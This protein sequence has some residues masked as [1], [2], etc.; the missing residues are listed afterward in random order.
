MKRRD[1]FRT[2]VPA[3]LLPS[4]LNGFSFR[5]FAGSP[6]MQALTSATLN[7]H[8]LI[9]IQLN[10]GNDGLNTV[11]PLDQYT[12][13]SA[14]RQNI[15]IPD[16]QVLQLNGY[17]DTGLHPSMTGMRQLFNDG[18]LN[19]VQGVGYPSP[20]FSH[21]RATDIWLTGSDSSQVLSSGWAGRYLN[22]EYPNFPT[23]YPNATMPDPLALQIGSTV[24]LALQGPSSSMAMAIS[25][26]TS[27]YNLINGVQDP[28]P[29][30]FAGKELTYIRTVAQQST[31]YSSVI[32]AAANNIT[33]QSSLYPAAGI[34]SLADQLKIVARLIAGGLKTKIY[35]VNLGG[36]DTH[37]SQVGTTT[38]SGTH[39]DLLAK[40][41]EAITAFMDD[42][43][44]LNIEHRVMGM[45]FSEFGRRIV[46]NSSDG[47]DHG[48]AAPLFV[49]GKDV[50][51]GILGTNPVIGNNV[52]VND[53]IP[54]QYD[55]RSVYASLLQDWFCVPSTDL[56]TVL[57]QNFQTLPLVQS[58]AC[59]SVG[60][61]EL[62]KSA[63]INLIENYPNP[64]SQSTN[65]DF[66]TSGGHTLVQ[67]FDNE[68]KLVKT[69][70]DQEFAAGKYSVRFENEGFTSGVYYARL[71]NG[72]IQQVRNMQIMR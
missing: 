46:S 8:A 35:M 61:H 65:V 4:L 6:L 48:A 71:Q 41:S 26:P 16:T 36:F 59:A 27:F 21:F 60:I 13:L 50:Q 17:A 25:D 45:T 47:T 40:L 67:V 63:G 28:A 69:L 12:N 42:T 24:S 7:D 2:A 5:A 37:S 56:S 19:I 22:Y 9:L 54:M 68:G 18:R 34:N 43:I 62:N 58:S 70:A 57:L 14:A 20:N 51:Q 55:F 31:L 39:A 33:Q 44:F 3:T 32:L 72:A 66:T 38:T 15:L 53:N 49:F 23:G 64:F 30:T 52:N 11:I 29:N 10:G 1:F